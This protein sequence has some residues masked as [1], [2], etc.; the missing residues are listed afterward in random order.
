M[1]TH[2]DTKEIS[3]M[4]K[5]SKIDKV[6]TPPKQLKTAKKFT[7]EDENRDLVDKAYNYWNSLSNIRV[8]RRRNIKYKNGDQWSDIVRDPENPSRMIREE[9]LIVRNGQIP[10]KHNIIGQVVRNLVGQMLSNPTYSTVFARNEKDQ[11]LSEMLTNALN[12]CHQINSIQKIDIAIIEELIVSGI[13]CVKVRYDYFHEKDRH[14]GK[15]DSVNINKLFFNSDVEDPRLLDLNFIGQ[16]HE[17]GID[18]IITNFA[19]ST[20]EEKQIRAIYQN[21]AAPIN[22]IEVGQSRADDVSF[23]YCID[24]S[25]YRVYEIWQR[26]GQWIKRIHDPLD[27]TEE[28]TTLTKK[29]ID[30]LNKERID[31]AIKSGGVGDE[32]PLIEMYEK[33]EYYWQ[34]K[35]I[36]ANGYTLKKLG[37]PYTHDSHPYVL[38]IMPMM[39]GEFKSYI[40]DLIDM[41]R[42]INRL[43]VMIDFSIGASA[44][45]VLMIPEDCIPEGYSVEDFAAEYVKANGVIVYR[46]SNKGNIPMQISSNSNPASA[47]NMLHTQLGLI[48]KVSGVSEAMQGRVSRS[49]AASLYEQ[50]VSNGQINYRVV[51][52][53][54]ASFIKERD[55]KLLKTLMQFY[56]EK[57]LIN[58]ASS[59]SNDSAKYWEPIDDNKIIDFN[60]SINQSFDTPIFRMQFEDRLANMLNGGHIN[61]ETYLKS[62]SMPF[63]KDMLAQIEIDKEKE[64]IRERI[65]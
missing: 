1:I 62:S 44:K 34:V 46:P 6:Q 9:E 17:Y 40:A 52:E 28:I 7:K 24:S 38:S 49:T 36:D 65:N 25:K 10:L 58:I 37:S 3:R 59:D 42:Y 32:V 47:W 23:H 22:S 12:S 33:Y 41:Q 63:S 57:R 13:G 30:D 14:D 60:L 5:L 27:G 55:E 4:V 15:V 54:F 19:S 8:E 64:V 61:F 31:I 18:E 43:L 26:K 39:D 35:F 45:G 50:Q 29:E 48:E 11:G 56:T 20:E 53:T 2:Y 21:A 51:F 16:L